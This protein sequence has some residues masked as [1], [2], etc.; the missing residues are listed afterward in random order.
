MILEDD[1]TVLEAYE[2]QSF[3]GEEMQPEGA[4]VPAEPET[5]FDAAHVPEEHDAE[6]DGFEAEQPEVEVASGGTDFASIKFQRENTLLTNAERYAD[7][8]RGEAELYVRQLQ[9]EVDALNVEAERRYEEARQVKEAG[10]EEARRRVEEAEQRVEEIRAQAHG[11]GFEQGR[12]EGL[13]QRYE[14]AGVYLEQ[15]EKILADL[16]H[17]REQVDHFMERDGIRMAVLIAKKILGQE[18]KVNKRIVWRLLAA[19]LAQME[20]KGNF[21]I[22]LSPEDFKFAT[23]AR[24]A[25]EKF[26]QEDQALTFR[27]R[28]DL[29]PGNAMIETDREVIDLSFAGQFHHVESQLYQVL[30]E[31]EGSVLNRPSALTPPGWKPGQ[32]QPPPPQAGEG[33]TPMAEPQPSADDRPVVELAGAEGEPQPAPAA[34]PADV[35]VPEDVAAAAQQMARQAAPAA[36]APAAQPSP[37]SEPADG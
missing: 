20:G 24:P 10:E 22:W 31:R 26:T 14:E 36:E 1:N 7:S 33:P 12:K 29:P 6:D 34:A 19:T 28:E 16:S 21:L 30:A 2:V 18:L 9:G 13:Q 8:I 11:E 23:A 5:R 35:A 4:L 25:L 15:L 17:F 3:D 27:S 32:Q 37:D